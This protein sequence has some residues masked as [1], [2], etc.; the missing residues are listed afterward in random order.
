M[1]I[2]ANSRSEDEM[3][4]KRW[5]KSKDRAD[6][7][8]QVFP[9]QLNPWL[10]IDF[11]LVEMMGLPMKPHGM[12]ESKQQGSQSRWGRR[13]CSSRHCTAAVFCKCTYVS[14][15]GIA[16]QMLTNVIQRI[17]TPQM[18]I[19]INYRGVPIFWNLDTVG[20]YGDKYGRHQRTQNPSNQILIDDH[21]ILCLLD[22]I[23]VKKSN[24]GGFVKILDKETQHS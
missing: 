1:N 17:K 4:T 3:I 19:D 14:I 23:G 12:E 15:G 2:T 7:S 10:G 20:C 24:D 22:P 9:P 8:N 13:H 18:I 11:F 21:V 6:F 16:P 5:D